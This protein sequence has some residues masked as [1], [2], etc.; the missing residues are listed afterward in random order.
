MNCLRKRSKK[1]LKSLLQQIIKEYVKLFPEDENTAVLI[2]TPEYFL[3]SFLKVYD[4]LKNHKKNPLELTGLLLKYES[5]ISSID[6][7]FLNG[8]IQNL[9]KRKIDISEPLIKKQEFFK[10]IDKTTIEK[11]RQKWIQVL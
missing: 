3:F 4:S 11:F 2:E 8:F 5:V 10:Y 7:K 9:Q 1:E 6:C